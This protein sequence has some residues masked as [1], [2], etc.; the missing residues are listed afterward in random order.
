MAKIIIFPGITKLD[1]PPER[2]VAKINEESLSE[3]VVLGWKPDGSFYFASSIADGGD[4]LWLLRTA[5]IKLL[6][7]GAVVPRDPS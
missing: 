2:I 4:V 6:Q 7:A 3:V 5:E 1:I